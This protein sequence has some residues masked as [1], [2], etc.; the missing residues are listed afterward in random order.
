MSWWKQETKTENTS[1]ASVS[2]CILFAEHTVRIYL[3]QI[4]LWHPY[5]GTHTS[6]PHSINTT[7]SPYQTLSQCRIC[8]IFCPSFSRYYIGE[9]Q[10]TQSLHWDNVP[11]S[12]R[13]HL[14]RKQS[15]DTKMSSHN[16]LNVIMKVREQ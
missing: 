7:P 6:Y 1:H 11:L 14:N 13:Q 9:M 4:F 10:P 3:P 5:M 12:E 15:K 2:T 16:F 8:K